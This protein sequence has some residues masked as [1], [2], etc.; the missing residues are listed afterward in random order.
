MVPTQCCGAVLSVIWVALIAITM[1]LIGEY[2]ESGV[3]L[4]AG[5]SSLL[6]N[7]F[8]PNTPLHD[9]P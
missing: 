1:K 9:G 6:I 5:L 8:V 2:M 3:D 7:I 4:D